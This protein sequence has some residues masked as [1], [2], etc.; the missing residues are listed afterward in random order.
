MM[1][2]AVRATNTSRLFDTLRYERYVTHSKSEAMVSR[3]R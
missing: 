2:G 3:V 1:S